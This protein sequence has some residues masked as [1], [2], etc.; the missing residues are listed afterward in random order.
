MSFPGPPLISVCIP[1][2]N[3]EL[4][5]DEAIR[6]VLGQTFG[7]FELIIVDDLSRDGT[8]EK[9]RAYDD[10]R[11]RYIENDRNLGLAANWNKAL[12]EARG[13]WIKV[14]PGD[15]LLYPRC[16]ERQIAAFEDQPPGE[17]AL[18]SCARDVIDERGRKIMRR[19]FPG[20]GRVIPG[21]EAVRR[22]IRAGTNL[23]GEPA[24]VLMRADLVERTG[25]FNP[26]N[27]YLIDLDFWARL[28]LEGSLS[29]SAD[30]LC[31]FRIS[32]T[33]ESTRTRS[34]Q[35]RDF[36]AFAG[37]LGSDV[38][39]GLKPVDLRRGRRRA[40]LNGFLRRLLYKGIL[41]GPR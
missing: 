28:L 15:D 2:F 30:P 39:F 6:S 5:I 27:V 26:G 34:S 4:F 24:A 13:R 37:V 35:S 8:R 40:V 38:R 31:A 29:M 14:L 22:C 16:L 19:A 11:I 1:S 20:K 12:G 32:R 9:I 17:I 33:A 7:G 18:V 23:I 41:S 21:R 10:P 3:N 25:L 36:Q